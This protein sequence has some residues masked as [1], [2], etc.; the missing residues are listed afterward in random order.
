MNAQQAVAD[1]IKRL[2][3]QN[4][5]TVNRLA[6]LSGVSAS[7]LNNTISLKYGAV[8]GIGIVKIQ[9]ICQACDI[10]LADFFADPIFT[11][12]EQEDG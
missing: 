6:N 12:L 10:T 3:K 4:K 8:K 1:K 7:A 11:Q 2:I 9:R 5:L